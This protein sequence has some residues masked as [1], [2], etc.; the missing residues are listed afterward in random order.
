MECVDDRLCVLQF[1]LE[2]LDLVFEIRY[3][4]LAVERL[5]LLVLLDL[6]SAHEFAQL[7]HVDLQLVM[8]PDSQLDLSSD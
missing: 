3:V 1:M 5:L 7:L 6:L 4:L 8:L 2:R